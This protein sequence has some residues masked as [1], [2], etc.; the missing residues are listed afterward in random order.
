MIIKYCCQ[1]HRDPTFYSLGFNGH[2][3]DSLLQFMTFISS[4]I[5]FKNEQSGEFQFYYVTYKVSAA[6][7]ID[8][9]KLT[10]PVRQSV[11]HTIPLYNPLSVSVTLNTQL[12]NSTEISLL[13]TFTVPANSEG[14][15]SFEYM[16][17]KAGRS[18]AKIIFNSADL[19]QYIYEVG[20]T[21]FV[22]YTF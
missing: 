4:Q 11:S 12:Q 16:P 5:T 18:D 22:Y 9:I 8:T 7:I 1:V 19:G 3:N 20:N 15:F 13:P 2:Q 10:A 14:L 17:L 6:G 21:Q